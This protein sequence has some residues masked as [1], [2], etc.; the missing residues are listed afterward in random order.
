MTQSSTFDFLLPDNGLPF[1]LITHESQ[2]SVIT[3]PHW[4]RALQLYFLYIGNIPKCQLRDQHFALGPLDLLVVNPYEVH[5]LPINPVNDTALLSIGIPNKFFERNGVNLKT[6]KFV[7]LIRANDPQNKTLQQLFQSLAKVQAD[8]DSLTKK[9]ASVG[10]V[11]L[12]LAEL[13]RAY[14][15]PERLSDT[16]QTQ[17]LEPALSWAD[18]H[19]TESVTV[20]SMAEQT[21]LSISY[22]AHLFKAQIGVT[23]LTYIYDLRLT[24]ACTQLINTKKSAK[25]ISHEIGFP[26]VKSF[27]RLFQRKYHCT[28]KQFRLTQKQD[29]S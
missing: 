13:L 24:D 7:N 17:E 5:A 10:L 23:P 18:A 2:T 1:K 9:T 26:D 21:H 29:F 20:R 19:F 22:F 28:P 25:A 6:N 4:H 14:R 12:I 11:Y 15:K 3:T 16:H 8:S 27:V